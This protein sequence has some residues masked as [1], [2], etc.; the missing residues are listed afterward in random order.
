[1]LREWS[2]KH[3]SDPGNGEWFGYLHRDGIPS[4]TLKGSLWKS[5][6]HHPRALWRC[7]QLAKGIPDF[8]LKTQSS[9]ITDGMAI[10]SHPVLDSSGSAL[11]HHGS[12][13]V[14]PFHIN[15]FVH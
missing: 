6:F 7:H 8:Q 13:A 15:P 10:T 5:F 14:K 2:F 3:F 12:T 1:M 4:N 11:L 9:N